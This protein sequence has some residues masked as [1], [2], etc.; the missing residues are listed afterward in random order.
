MMAV[1]RSDVEARLKSG[2]TLVR[3]L[4][5]GDTESEDAYQ[6]L[7]GG[8]NVTKATYAALTGGKKPKLKPISPGLFSDSE[9]QEWGW[10]GA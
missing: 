10:A 7:S 6:Y 3:V 2:E 4:P 8:G 9:P 5:K 1:K